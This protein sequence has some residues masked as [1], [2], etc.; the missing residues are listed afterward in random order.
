MRY[1][2]ILGTHPALSVAEIMAMIE[3]NPS[4]VTAT[5]EFL[6][7]ETAAELDVPALMNRLGGTIKIGTVESVIKASEE[8]IVDAI[9]SNLANAQPAIRDF[10]VSL[11]GFSKK[12]WE[13]VRD[14]G[15][16][17]KKR[18]REEKINSRWVRPQ[19]ERALTSVAVAKNGLLGAGREFCVIRQGAEV[20]FG[21]TRAVQAF[22][23]FS[24]TDYGRPGRDT[25]QGMLPPKLARMMLNVSGKM[26]NG[27]SII[28]DPFCGSGT[29]LT[30]AMRLGLGTVFG[31]DLN[32]GAI[33][34]TEENI[35]W[36][37]KRGDIPNEVLVS[38]FHSDARSIANHIRDHRIDAVVTEPFLGPPRRGKETRGE[39][40]RTLSDLEKLYY[41]ALSAWKKMLKPDSVVILALP[42]YI[43]GEEKHGIS[44]TS[45]AKLGYKVEPFMDRDLLGKLG[46]EQTKNGGLLYGRAGQWVWREVIKLKLA[47]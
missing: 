39:L 46:A 27:T 16:E 9:V 25:H 10:G 44:T 2:F 43:T 13:G 45:F 38:L 23:D 6:V 20:F 4:L 1:F 37:K 34:Q 12:E 5:R 35:I 41:E 8:D 19:A 15:M 18:L 30:E 22:E 40:Q 36:F 26:G 17:A 14:S 31:G 28:L 7:L 24:Q 42:V 32:P 33:K 47:E 29:V 11:Y 3:G 21:I